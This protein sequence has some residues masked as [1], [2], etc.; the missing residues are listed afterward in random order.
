MADVSLE[1][2]EVS[3]TY[4]PYHEDLMDKSRSGG[5]NEGNVFVLK[6]VFAF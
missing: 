3:G 4:F 5:R 6:K 2:D 1:V